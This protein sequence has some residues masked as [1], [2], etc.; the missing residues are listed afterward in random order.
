MSDDAPFQ[1][2]DATSQASKTYN[3]MHSLDGP[4][5]PAS[6]ADQAVG[7]CTIKDLRASVF[8]TRIHEVVWRWVQSEWIAINNIKH[9][10]AIRGKSQAVCRRAI[11]DIRLTPVNLAKRLDNISEA[12]LRRELQKCG[13]STPGGIIRRARLAFGKHLLAHTRM[14]VRDV[15]LRSG[16][17]DARHFAILFKEEEGCR[18]L[19]FRRMR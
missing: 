7:S 9:E 6:E 16:Y 3:E 5:G 8:L 12:T 1:L 4:F 18:P 15:A 11:A 17:A 2:R 13:A 10:A 19:E 14:P